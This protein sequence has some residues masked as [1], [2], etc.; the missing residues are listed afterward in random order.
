V[1]ATGPAVTL[2]T[3]YC[4]GAAACQG[5]PRPPREVIL[6][7]MVRD[8]DAEYRRIAALGVDW[9]LPPTTQPWG[10]RSMVFGDPEGNL[11]NVFSRP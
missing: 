11:V 1:T 8:V 5:A 7:F 10:S 3:A 9:V 2:F 6:D 4:A